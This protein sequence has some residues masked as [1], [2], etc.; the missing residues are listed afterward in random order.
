MDEKKSEPG[1]K[2]E[3]PGRRRRSGREASGIEKGTITQ[4]RLLPQWGQQSCSFTQNMVESGSK[5]TFALESQLIE[6]TSE[7]PAERFPRS[8]P[9]EV[10]CH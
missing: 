7:V 5:A 1:V 9:T 10:N 3:G 2:R 4:A 6:P 8:V